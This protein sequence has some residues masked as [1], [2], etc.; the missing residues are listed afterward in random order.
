VGG[1]IPAKALQY[2]FGIKLILMATQQAVSGAGHDF[3]EEWHR[4]RIQQGTDLPEA[5][6]FTKKPD[7]P[8]TV[9]FPLIEGNLVPNIKGEEG[10]IR[11]ETKKIL[12]KYKNGGIIDANI[13]VGPAT[14]RVGVKD[15]HSLDMFLFLEKPFTIEEVIDAWAKYKPDYKNYRLPSAPSFPILYLNDDFSP[16]PRFDITREDGMAVILGRAR[17]YVEGVLQFKSLSHNT[18]ICKPKK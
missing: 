2:K 16:Q 13:E 14:S 18:K 12:G 7:F 4:Q 9:K 1:V 10:K 11:K 6:D 3:E 17:T 5:I 8:A 15:G